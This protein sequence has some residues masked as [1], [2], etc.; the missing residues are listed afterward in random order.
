MPWLESLAAPSW[1]EAKILDAYRS[2]N[3]RLAAGLLEAWSQG[4]MRTGM[5]STL[6]Y[7]ALFTL[8]RHG[9]DQAKAAAV[10]GAMAAAWNPQRDMRGWQPPRPA[11][12]ARP[13][14]DAR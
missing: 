7:V 6:S 11:G 10:A 8:N 13:T 12:T 14:Q 9:F 1:R 2:A 3:A 4:R 5:R